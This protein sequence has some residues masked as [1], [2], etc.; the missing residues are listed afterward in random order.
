MTLIALL[1]MDL[2]VGGLDLAASSG[3]AGAGAIGGAAGIVGAL[4]SF[5]AVAK[6]VDTWDGKHGQPGS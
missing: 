3:L 1:L 2:V 4:V 6:S 5:R